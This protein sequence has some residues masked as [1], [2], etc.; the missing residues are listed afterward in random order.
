MTIIITK[1][2]FSIYIPWS[3]FFS[4]LMKGWVCELESESERGHINKHKHK[5][6]GAESEAEAEATHRLDWLMGA[7]FSSSFFLRFLLLRP[8]A[9][10]RRHHQWQIMAS[11]ASNSR[12]DI[13]ICTQEQEKEK[14]RNS[15]GSL[16]CQTTVESRF[17]ILWSPS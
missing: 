13:L 12:A 2:S 9:A 15:P 10:A 7:S 17:W 11:F 6:R 1:L 5:H 14:A 3:L 4:K 16:F 8:A